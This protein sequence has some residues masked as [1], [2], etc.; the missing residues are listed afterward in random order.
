[1]VQYPEVC[2]KDPP[3]I[4]HAFNPGNAVEQWCECWGQIWQWQL[5][6]QVPIYLLVHVGILGYFSPPTYLT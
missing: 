6:V 2:G 1:M 3:K 5:Q 4:P